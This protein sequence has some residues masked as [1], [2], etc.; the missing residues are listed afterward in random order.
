MGSDSK[1]PSSYST[2]IDED[3]YFP[4]SNANCGRMLAIINNYSCY[5]K[6]N[7]KPVELRASIN[8]SPRLNCL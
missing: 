5:S 8:S 2:N 6:C 3:G 4:S 7:V 1:T